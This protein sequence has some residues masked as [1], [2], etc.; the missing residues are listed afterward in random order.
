MSSIVVVQGVAQL[1]NAGGL[2]KRITLLMPQTTETA[3]ESSTT[4]VP[5]KS[6]WASVRAETAR[7]L[8]RNNRTEAELNY[9]IR[10]RFDSE[11][12]ESWRLRY[13]GRTLE[14]SKVLDILQQH[15]A[16]EIVASEVRS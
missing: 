12:T 16:L 2:N 7:E 8:V 10:I 13:E 14:I 11:L 1:L 3:G 4:Y 6:V 15:D 5:V 9:F